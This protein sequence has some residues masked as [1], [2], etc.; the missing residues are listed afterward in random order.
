MQH[1]SDTQIYETMKLLANEYICDTELAETIDLI[2]QGQ[3]QGLFPA[4]KWFLHTLSSSK[5]T[6]KQLSAEHI[7]LYQQIC[8]HCI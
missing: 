1:L 6:G 7:E 4:G 2:N 5:K 8:A 3:E